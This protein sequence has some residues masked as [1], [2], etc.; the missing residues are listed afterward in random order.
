MVVTSTGPLYD[1]STRSP[2]IQCAKGLTSFIYVTLNFMVL[3]GLCK[4]SDPVLDKHVRVPIAL[5]T[6]DN[7]LT[8]S[9][10]YSIDPNDMRR[11]LGLNS[12]SKLA[13]QYES[14]LGTPNDQ[15]FHTLI[16]RP[17]SA[18]LAQSLHLSD[19]T[20]RV[21]HEPY[22]SNTSSLFV[23][24][25]L[26]NDHSQYIEHNKNAS[27]IIEHNKQIVS[28]VNALF[29]PLNVYIALTGVIIWSDKNEIEISSN[30]D[31]TLTNF[32]KYRYEKLLPSTR[33]DN[34][35][36]I[37]S[38]SFNDSVVGKALKGT[39][40]THEFSGGI[41]SAHSDRVALVAATVA[42]EIGHN[43]NMEHD[44]PNCTCAAKNCI[45]LASS[46]SV[47]P[48]LWSSCSIDRLRD[49]VKLGLT[50]C[51]KQPP[52]DIV[53]P[54]C[55][56]SFIEEGEQCDPGFIIPSLRSKK[57]SSNATDCISSGTCD[58]N[59]CC[60]K[61]TCRFAPNSTCSDGPCCDRNT[62]TIVPAHKKVSCREKQSECDFEEYC[63]GTSEFCPP[64]VYH[65][66][67]IECGPTTNDKDIDLDSPQTK[68]Y[69]RSLAFCYQGQCRSHESQC[70]LLWGDSGHV[71]EDLCF[72]QNLHG[73]ASGN[74]GYDR[75]TKTFH[76]CEPSDTQCGMLHCNHFQNN[77]N[78]SG[79]SAGRLMY[80]LESSAILS[81]SFTVN[82]RVKNSK[83]DIRCRSAIIDAGQGI[84]DPGL[85]PDGA[86][87]GFNHMCVRQKCVSVQAIRNKDWCESECNGNGICDNTGVCHCSDGSVGSS[88]HRF[89]GPGFNFTVALYFIF[90]FV[91]VLA[92]ALVS[93]RHFKKQIEIWWY[94]RERKAA[95]NQR[96][97]KLST[98]PRYP[99]QANGQIS[100]LSISG[101]MPIQAKN[102]PCSYDPFDDP[103]AD[104][105][106]NNRYRL[107]PLQSYVLP[108]P[109]PPPSERPNGS[110]SG[111]NSQRPATTGLPPLQSHINFSKK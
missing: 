12:G 33:H 28:Y 95:L 1:I 109:P 73:N 72:E 102:A 37:T 82:P 34:A 41:V 44:E 50:Q 78:D 61:K 106:D 6:S 92:I 15:Y 10:K 66:D 51:L 55:G 43:F 11:G 83:V 26:V 80:G 64:N 90:F 21:Y 101:P 86:Y 13:P 32:L 39:I 107:E 59:T 84:Q 19:Q 65:H 49:A 85:T 31:T 14:T 71:S 46:G 4:T 53:G 77:P 69:N 38:T 36:L 104:S 22:L 103:W 68:N 52:T 105:E 35:Q 76:S 2:F 110:V 99:S 17:I 91:P 24:L 70:R 29:R 18:R 27:E 45:M 100:D 42:H 67:G 97:A 96:A 58:I 81:R 94:L 87:C 47:A 74:C 30:G 20:S 111:D 7:V 93:F 79:N 25:L 62:C 5:N 23:R 88:C 63:D 89:F 108:T 60:D 9:Q 8:A 16:E 98:A 56:N 75:L 48:G 40:C 54:V 57:G 3:C